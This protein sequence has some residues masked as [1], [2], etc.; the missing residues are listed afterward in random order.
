MNT[1][2]LTMFSWLWPN[3]WHRN[4]EYY[5]VYTNHPFLNC[6]KMGIVVPIHD[7]Q[8]VQGQPGH[9]IQ[10]SVQFHSFTMATI[11]DQAMRLFSG[12]EGFQQIVSK[13]LPVI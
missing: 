2:N 9:T 12:H 10:T 4:K 6:M 13:T 7:T 8:R 11:T 5:N 3:E 1:I